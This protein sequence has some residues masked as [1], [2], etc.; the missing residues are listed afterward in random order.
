[1][2]ETKSII[3]QRLD[4]AVALAAKGFNVKPCLITG[5]TRK[6]P[7]PQARRVVAKMLRNYGYSYPEI[8]RVMNR[9]HT[10]IMFMVKDDF[11]ANK[12]RYNKE[13]HYA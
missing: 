13:R 3:E 11:R 7:Y 9:N 1:M 8:G 5:R 12:M 10:S 4:T 2:V 6:R